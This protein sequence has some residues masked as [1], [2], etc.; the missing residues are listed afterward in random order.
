MSDLRFIANPDISVSMHDEGIVILHLGS[1]RMY[2]S[3][4]TGASIWRQ[5]ERQLPIEAITEEICAEYRVDRSTS[6]KHVVDFLTEL[7]QHALV[8]RKAAW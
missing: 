3:N 1:G 2:T 7:E 4:K 8:Q 6:R 5:V